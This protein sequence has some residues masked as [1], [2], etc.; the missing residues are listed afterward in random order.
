M[1]DAKYT[2]IK[3]GAL[4]VS[5][6]KIAWIGRTDELNKEISDLADQVID[7]RGK[8]I[9]PG[10]VDCHTHLIWA[11]SRS[12]EFEMR[13]A[14]KTY[15]QIASQGGGIFSTVN[16]VRKASQTQLFD[17]AA[18]RVQYFLTQGITCV[19]IKSGY[20]LDLENELKMLAVARRLGR[21]LPVHV[22]PT[23][24]GAHALP[25]EFS[26][27]SD[28][29]VD[30]VTETMLPCVKDQNIA[31]A[32]DVFCETIA[33]SKDQTRTLFSK[34]RDLGFRV[35]L[36]AEQL[37][38][39]KG[40][41]L[42]SEFEALS[43]DH[44]EYL[45][46]DGVRAMARKNVVAV[47]LPGA[48]YMLKETQTPPIDLL[49]QYGVPMALA[50]D[51]NPGT[52][53]VFSMAPVI[54]M[55]CLLFGMTCEEAVARATI[56][57]A[58]ALGLDS[59]KGSLEIGKDADLVVWDIDSPADLAYLIGRAPVNMVAVSGKIEYKAKSC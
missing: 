21:E 17:T 18:K 24:L 47:L 36:H 33:F 12:T 5:G 32:V 3:N 9:L 53:P 44:L 19:E 25:P 40:A 58:K 11:G 31:T 2:T 30:L 15:E 20:G 14:G 43:C 8:W 7:C 16:A 39:N 22:E 10:F 55:G 52:S 59:K 45:S 34:A 41:Q 42:A 27:R 29:Y 37:S 46:L 28:D 49:R 57:G 54:N 23:F 50:T 26:G 48:F 56:N 35:K 38:D 6:D 13:L 1:T 51:L 4:A